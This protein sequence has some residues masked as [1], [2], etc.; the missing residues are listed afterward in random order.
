MAGTRRERS[1]GAIV[2][3]A[4]TALVAV[5]A[6]MLAPAEA[7]AQFGQN[8]DYCADRSPWK[9]APAGFDPRNVLTVGV[10]GGGSVG[11]AMHN[12]TADC[13]QGDPRPCGSASCR[14][15]V[16]TVCSFHCYSHLHL[17]PQHW[18]VRLTPSGA[19]FLGWSGS[20]CRPVSSATYGRTSCL[21]LMSQDRSVTAN[22]GAP[23]TTAP[24]PAPVVSV[25]PQRYSMAISWTPSADAWLAGYE[26]WLGGKLAVRV[27]RTTTQYTANNLLCESSY[28][29]RVVAYDAQNEAA[30]AE[31]PAR[32]GACQ[33]AARPR[34]RT[35]IHVKPRRTTRSRTAFFHF[36]SVGEIRATR[37]QCKLDR[38]RWGRCSGLHGKRYR[39]L[40]RGVHTFSVRAGNAAGYDRTPARWRW[41]IR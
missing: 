30:S 3:I 4:L 25:S 31:A 35:V 6:V 34:P 14:Y 22:F 39:A 2:R 15:E 20:E 32:T 13:I 38:G 26:V 41:R 28:P 8:S 36:G 40:G 37:Y 7:R 33:P 23:D 1:A 24:A 9:Q 11:L 16:Q 17:D 10:V 19:G 12:T 29:V 21:A 18:D 5:I 27:P